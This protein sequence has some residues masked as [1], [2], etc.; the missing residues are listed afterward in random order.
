[1][2]ISDQRSEPRVEVSGSTLKFSGRTHQLKNWSLSG[3]LV[4]PFDGHPPDGEQFPITLNV[5]SN[6][7][8]I[9]LEG[10]ATVIRQADGQLAGKWQLNAPAGDAEIVIRYFLS[11][12]E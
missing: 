9:E 7:G 11:Y 4:S 2:G 6:L 8:S 1:M 10:S 12:P 3:F 5:E